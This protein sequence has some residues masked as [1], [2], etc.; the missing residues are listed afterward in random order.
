MDKKLKKY[1]II[2]VFVIFALAAFWHF[3]FELIPSTLTAVISPVNESVWEHVKL[4]YC[5]A[6]IWYVI[7]Y[8][9]VGKHY[10]NYIFSHALMLIVMPALV[11]L[12]HGLWTLLLPESVVADIVFTFIAIAL[13]SY[14]AY[15][16]TLSRCRLGG[17]WA[18]LSAA[19]IVI[20][21][22]VVLVLFTFNPPNHPLFQIA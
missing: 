12:L 14:A 15:K 3:L 20:A 7:M 18:K 10:P 17:A 16:L 22:L 1:S 13:A 6:I 4:F 9:A 5:P 11:L 8:A 19:L 2:G 21:I